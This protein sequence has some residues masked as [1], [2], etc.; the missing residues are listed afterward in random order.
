VRGIAGQSLFVTLQFMTGN[1]RKIAA[2][3]Q[4]VADGTAQKPAERV[5][6]RRVTL[7]GYR[8]PP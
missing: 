1:F 4:M 6:R 5:R 2:F 7:A 3:R 8:P